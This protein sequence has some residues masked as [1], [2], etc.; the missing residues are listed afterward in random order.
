MILVLMRVALLFFMIGAAFHARGCSRG[1]AGLGLAGA[2]H[3]AELPGWLAERLH[4]SQAD[5]E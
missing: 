5:H 3:V 2:G 1:I 4:S